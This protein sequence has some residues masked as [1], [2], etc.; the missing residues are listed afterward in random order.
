LDG[1]AGEDKIAGGDGWDKLDGG[2]GDD[3]LTGGKGR[4]ALWGGAGDDQIHGGSDHDKLYDGAGNDLLSGGSG[5]DQL[6]SA[7]GADTL[8]GGEGRDRLESRSDAGEPAPAQGGD[9][10]N[11]DFNPTDTDDVLTSGMDRDTFYFR[12][13]LNAKQAIAA[14]HSDANGVI[15]WQ[16]VAG[17][18]GDVHDHWV[19]GIGNDLITDYTEGQDKIIIE[20][21]TVNVSFSMVDG[22][23]DG[24]ADDTLITL[25]SNQGGT[26][27]DPAGAHDQ[28]P[29]GTITVLNAELG[30]NDV[31]VNAGVFYG[32]FETLAELEAG[33]M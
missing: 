11:A 23:G 8:R 6:Y 1:G 5:W 15:D 21:H 28:D 33:W 16:A 24:S 20:G 31:T 9:R 27:A 19:D 10:V 7:L 14:K 18:N 22:D 32:A 3:I 29:L 2:N 4:D 13:D 17:E 12:L 25:I 30:A 26:A